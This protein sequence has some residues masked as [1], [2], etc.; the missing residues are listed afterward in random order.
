MELFLTID[1]LKKIPQDKLPMVGLTNGYMSLFGFV[2]CTA[3]HD[4]WSHAMW[5]ISPAEF[6]SQWFWFKTFP[7]DHY[8][9]H[10]IK[11]WYNPDWTPEERTILQAAIWDR[12]QLPWYKTRYDVIGV[13]GEAIGVK[14]LNRKNLDFCSESIRM[15]SLVDKEYK[16]WLEEVKNPTPEEVNGFLKQQKKPEG[17]PKYVV[18]GRVQP[19]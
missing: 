15:L 12:L 13:I 5:L 6:A 8:N 11:L 9:R 14:W 4:F 7:V 2:I 17:M 19:G 16:K 10:S 18:Y 1:D 3:T